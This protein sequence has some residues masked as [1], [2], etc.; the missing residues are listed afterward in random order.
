[1]SNA[2]NVV[3]VGT[4]NVDFMIIGEAPRDM[5]ILNKWV[6][7]AKVQMTP[8]GSVGYCAVDMARLGLNVSLLSS[9]ADDI[10]GEWILKELEKQGVMVD[11]VG[12][13]K[14]S[15]SGIG[16]YMLLFGNNKRP[17]AARLGSHPP[18]PAELSRKQE[19]HLKNAKLLHCSGYLHY[20]E[21]W[22]E[23]TEK[24]YRKAKSLGLKTSMDTQFPIIEVDGAWK[25]CFGNLLN[26]IDY[27]FTD[28]HEAKSITGTSG[29][30]A[31]ARDL[32]KEGPEIVVI[33]QGERGALISTEDKS[34][35]QPVYPMRDVVDSIGAGDAFDAGFI[36]GL[37]NGWEL[38][39]S[40][41]FASITAALT[42]RGIGGTQTAP[43]FDEVEKVFSDD[44]KQ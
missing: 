36:Y 38:E 32:L 7:P 12:I 2:L 8:A 21:M 25:K 35:S 1:M 10:F 9:V 19:D 30:E 18:W 41:R 23:P 5:D 13:E 34:F 42:L 43:T 29:A 4:L 26:D 6:G 16:I 24:L 37:L 17:L 39:K 28:E 15:I 14:N 40:A 33:K 44:R 22:G 31:A 11:A 27:L 3:A 20:C